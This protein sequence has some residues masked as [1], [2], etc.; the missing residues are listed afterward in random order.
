MCGRFSLTRVDVIEKFFGV[1]TSEISSELKPRY[2]I[3]PSQTSPVILEESND[4]LSIA[5]WGLIP[6]WAKDP[7]IGNKMI[8]ARAEGIDEK[9]AFRKPFASQRCLVLADGFYEWKKVGNSKIPFRIERKDK[10]L[11][12]FAGLYDK[13]R[14]SE[15]K[16][17]TTFIIITTKP[18]KTLEKIHDRMPVILLPDQQKKWLNKYNDNNKDNLFELLKPSPDDILNS[19]AISNI[20]NSPSNDSPEVIKQ[21]SDVQKVYNFE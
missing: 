13:W 12:A 4:K 1:S 9:P 8:N 21:I 6:H 7:S 20:I 19:Y 16:I 14:E 15:N 2:N 5:K 18:N 3:A 17:I 11:F 10:E